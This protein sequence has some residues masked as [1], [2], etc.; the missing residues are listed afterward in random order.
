[1]SA[2]LRD[3]RDDPAPTDREAERSMIAVYPLQTTF[4]HHAWSMDSYA[5]PIPAPMR[6][7]VRDGA[8]WRL[9]VHAAINHYQPPQMG[10]AERVA[11]ATEYRTF[12]DTLM[13][14][15]PDSAAFARLV[16]HLF[17]VARCGFKGC[18][19]PYLRYS[20]RVQ[21]CS[22]ECRRADA[23][24]PGYGTGVPRSE[25]CVVCGGTLADRR[26]RYCGERCARLAENE[27]ARAEEGRRL[28][29]LTAC[30]VCGGPLTGLRRRNC[31]DRCARQVKEGRRK[32]RGAH[33]V[34]ID[35]EGERT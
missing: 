1:V 34:T 25:A 22:D 18:R 29:P 23:G 5:L 14:L 16:L 28:P 24:G 3:D 10:A 4:R 12:L 13:Y 32:T 9:A 2:L 21:H 19:E 35:G 7:L 26:R 30:Q 15:G 27:A 11:R 33:D 6:R 8:A 20:R 17:P 31:S